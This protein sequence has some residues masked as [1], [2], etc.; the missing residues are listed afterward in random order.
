MLE[1]TLHLLPGGTLADK[2]VNETDENVY[3]VALTTAGDLTLVGGLYLKAT[4]R[5]GKTVLLADIAVNGVGAG[6][7]AYQYANSEE[8]RAAH[9]DE[10]ILRLAAMGPGANSLR[11]SSAKDKI[12]T[13]ASEAPAL[14]K[15]TQDAPNASSLYG[16]SDE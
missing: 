14:S 9:V 4:T 12:A 7:A 15:V 8:G 1:T 11:L 3:Y 2:L 10:F 13:A 5:P 6:A 16:L